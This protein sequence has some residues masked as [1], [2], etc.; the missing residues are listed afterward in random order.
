VHDDEDEVRTTTIIQNKTI[1]QTN[2]EN[3]SDSYDG[4]E[5]LVKVI[6]TRRR[7]N[8]NVTK[9]DRSSPSK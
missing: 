4:N 2:Q 7:K 3:Q 6:I 5:Q 1:N 8:R 9:S